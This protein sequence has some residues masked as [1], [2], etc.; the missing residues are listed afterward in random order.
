MVEVLV[1]EKERLVVEEEQE[2]EQEEEEEQW[3]LQLEKEEECSWEQSDVK[4]ME[5]FQAVIGRV[6]RPTTRN[7]GNFIRSIFTRTFCRRFNKTTL[8]VFEIKDFTNINNI[9]N[10]IIIIY[11][12]IINN[13]IIINI[14]IIP[15]MRR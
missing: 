4:E 6:L 12:I 8:K 9:I 10:I 15:G 5:E 1:P 13:T 11:N 7:D 2:E 14:N 3:E